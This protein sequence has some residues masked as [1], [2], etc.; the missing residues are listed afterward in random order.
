MVGIE[1]KSRETAIARA[2]ELFDQGDIWDDTNDVPLLYDEYEENG[3]AGIPLE[4]SVEEEI[5][6]D[7]PEA[8]GCV[9]AIHR[10]EAAFQAARLL[11]EAYQRGEKR[12]GNIDWDELGQ[13]HEAA[14][15]SM[16]ASLEAVKQ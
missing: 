3:D 16:G 4:F 12:G 5:I 8:A 1:A 6:G 7:W 15:K 13:A 10:T 2:N 14:L 9:K 11:V